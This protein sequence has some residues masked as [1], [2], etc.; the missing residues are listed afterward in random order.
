MKKVRNVILYLVILGLVVGLMVF[1]FGS[2]KEEPKKYT[3]ILTYFEKGKVEEFEIINTKLILKLENPDAPEKPIEETYQLYSVGLFLE[4]IDQY[5]KDENGNPTLTYDLITDNSSA[6]LSYLPT[7]LIGVI[8]VGFLVFFFIQM[9]GA[10]GGKAMSF[11]KAKLKTNLDSKRKVTFADVAGAEEEKAEL[12]EVVEFLKNPKRFTDMGARIPKGILLV[13]PPGTGKTYLAKAT[14]GEAGVPFFSISGSDFVELYVGV[15]ASR[16]R[17]VFDQAAKNAPCIVFIDEIDAVGRQR[18]A[19][20]GGGHDERE[21]TLNQ[22]LVEMDGFNDNSG[23]IIMAAT[24]RPDVLDNALLRPGRFDRQIVINL[25][26]V[27]AREE[28]LKIHSKNKPMSEEIDFSHLAKSTSGFSPADL[29]N[30]L[31][32]AALFAARRK[33]AKVTATDID[34][35][36]LKVI[37]GIEKKSNLVTEEDKKITAAHEA[38]HAIV[39]FF[40]ESELKVHEIS[41]IPRGLAA[42]YTYY[43]PKEDK[44]HYTKKQML[45]QLA[46]LLGGRAAEDV[47][48][49]DISAGASNDIERATELARKMVTRYGMSEKIGTMSLGSDHNEVFLGRDFA[50]QRN[51][52]EDLASVIDSEIKRII[53]TAY[54]TA[55]KILSDNMDKLELITNELIKREKITGEEF[56]AL[57]NGEELTAPVAENK[58]EE[59]TVN[60]EDIKADAEEISPNTSVSTD[61]GVTAETPKEETAE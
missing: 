1:L 13:G 28:V 3:D 39:S 38:G 18:G 8:M 55:K 40:L 26:D 12:V 41:I 19:G 43:V 2:T 56:K 17:D 33:H 48:L 25:P 47:F 22:L 37:I 58:N 21:Q 24:N 35:A 50:Q 30:L 44:N 51:T 7:I 15:G 60:N 52:S 45:T 46:G 31:N 54:D 16:V 36:I 29:E 6:W 20:L 4:D 42:G 23:I 9:R 53:D 34:D 49:D 10:S 32:E 14:S 61:E 11:A 5:I 27:K 59:K 57:M